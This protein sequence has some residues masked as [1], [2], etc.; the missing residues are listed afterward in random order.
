MGIFQIRNSRNG[1]VFIGKTR[2]IQASLNRSRFELT[3]G[4]HK[5]PDLQQD[6]K[7][8]EPENFEFSTLDTLPQKEG[9]S[10]DVEAE[11]AALEK[12]WLEKLQPF[13]HKGYHL[14]A[15]QPPHR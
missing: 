13:G 11:L 15:S 3:A 9:V 4:L 5:N 14:I 1:K 7:D 12:Q 8:S 2:D 10:R 6:W